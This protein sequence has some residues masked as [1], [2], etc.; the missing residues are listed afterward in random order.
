[1]L[2]KTTSLLILQYASFGKASL[3]ACLLSYSLFEVS[4]GVSVVWPRRIHQA[5]GDSL[6]FKP[7]LQNLIPAVP[8]PERLVQQSSNSLH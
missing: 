5:T 1:M 6:S 3:K 2:P 4:R 7:F 8:F